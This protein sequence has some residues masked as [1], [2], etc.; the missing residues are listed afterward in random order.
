MTTKLNPDGPKLELDG[1][2][3]AGDK[4]SD[5]SWEGLDEKPDKTKENLGKIARAQKKTKRT[6]G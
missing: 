4:L 2:E 1:E 5:S 3:Q 6:E